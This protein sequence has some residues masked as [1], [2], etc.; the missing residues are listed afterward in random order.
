MNP[1]DDRPTDPGSTPSSPPARRRRCPVKLIL[2][3]SA[4][5]LLLTVG[6]TGALVMVLTDSTPE[7]IPTDREGQWLHVRMTE[8]LTDAPGNEGMLI[9]PMDM[10]PLTTELAAAIR[11]AAEDPDVGGL[12][13]ETGPLAVG[14]SQVQEIRDAIL[15]FGASE[16]PCMAWGDLLTNK[17]F[18]LASACSDLR[19]APAGLTLVNGLHISQMYFKGAFDRFGISPNFAHVGDFKS[20]VEPYERTGPSPAAAEAQ[21]H[22]L[23]SLYGQMVEGIATGRGVDADTVLGWINDPPMSPKAALDAGMIDGLAYRDEVLDEID[24][25]LWGA[26][27]YVTEMREDW[28]GRGPA[29]A[30]LHA[31][32]TIVSGSSNSGGFGGQLV[33]DRTLRRQLREVREDDNILALVLRVNSPGGSGSASD[34]I[35]REVQR[36]REVKP[37]VV[38]MSDYAASGGYYIAMGADYVVAQPGTLTGSIGVFGGKMNFTGVLNELGIEVHHTERGRYAGL[39][40]ALTDFDDQERKKFQEF[41]EGFY[42]TFVSRAAEGRDMDFDEL[43]AVA[44]GRVWTGAQALEHGL[45][46]ELG[47]LDVAIAKARELA[48]IEGDVVYRRFPERRGFFEQLIEELTNPGGDADMKALSTV[49]A[50]QAPET[51]DALAW[52]GGLQAVLGHGGVAAMLPSPVSV[53]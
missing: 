17:E 5:G 48:E 2:W 12:F 14:W 41:L 26:D 21:A 43:H 20:A 38:S 28:S 37:V 40:S 7:I 32:G 45:V 30:I 3:I 33:G 15:A 19:F 50:G 18:Y 23:D 35:W 10:P 47:G 22:L 31:E 1:T 44:Q 29:I 39:F 16:K 34:S 25:D 46:D 13:L 6:I 49:L 36:T 53:R 11:R 9:D 51:V 4:F 52:L 8:Q 24:A 42:Q 27:A